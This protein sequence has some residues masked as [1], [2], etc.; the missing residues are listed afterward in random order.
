MKDMKLMKGVIRKAGPGT[1]Q[2]AVGLS[3]G[4]RVHRVWRVR[5]GLYFM[6]FMLFM[7]NNPG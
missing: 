3:N 5:L 6:S 2:R 4:A 1:Y 7:V